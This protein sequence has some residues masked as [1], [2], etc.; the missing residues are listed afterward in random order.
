MTHEI[1][2]YCNYRAQTRKQLIT[3]TKPRKFRAIYETVNNTLVRS[4]LPILV[5]KRAFTAVFYWPSGTLSGVK[6]YPKQN[7]PI[8][9]DWPQL[10]TVLNFCPSKSQSS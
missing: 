8:T 4:V 5:I 9:S 1:L 3:Y 6:F 10:F 2:C 7:T